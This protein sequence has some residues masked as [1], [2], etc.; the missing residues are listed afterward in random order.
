MDLQNVPAN[1]KFLWQPERATTAIRDGESGS[2]TPCVAVKHLDL[3]RGVHSAEAG[4]GGTFYARLS[5]DAMNG[6]RILFQSRFQWW[7]RR[8]RWRAMPSGVNTGSQLRLIQCTYVGVCQKG[9][10]RC[11]NG[12]A[13]GLVC[14]RKTVKGLVGGWIAVGKVELASSSLAFMVIC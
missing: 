7:L 14:Q 5:D 3:A 9:F 4:P 1:W 11:K 8:R 13:K 2:F 12:I 10:P 6:S